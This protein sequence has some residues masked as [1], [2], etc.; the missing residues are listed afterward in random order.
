MIKTRIL[1]Q[2]NTER[3]LFFFSPAVSRRRFPVHHSIITEMSS[4]AADNDSKDT[5]GDLVPF[6][7]PY[8]YG[9]YKSPFYKETHK[10]FRARVR[11]F[12]E[13]ELKPHVQE[14]E[15]KHDYP[16]D[17]HVKAYKAGI[18]SPLWPVEYGGTPPTDAPF[19]AFHELIWIDEL[20][21]TGC[22][23]VLISCF[24]IPTFALPPVLH[25]GP[26]E[27]KDTVCPEVIQGKKVIALAITEP[28]VRCL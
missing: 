18:L 3:G 14:W 12:V 19:D 16:T 5:F 13:K 8:W 26:Q 23:G 15:E 10:K 24:F 4:S 6:G 22:G 7:D 25:H 11:E 28:T 21:R 20:N 17:L 2:E 27:M 9:K 1:C